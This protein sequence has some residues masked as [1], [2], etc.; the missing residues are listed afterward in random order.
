[1]H[2]RVLI[3]GTVPYNKQSSSRAFESYFHNWEKENLVQIY[4]NPREPVHGHCSSFYQITDKRMLMRHFNK[5]VKTGVIFY[6]CE[7][8]DEWKPLSEKQ[9]RSLTSKLYGLGSRK[10]PMNYLMRGWL[11]KQK[12]WCVPQLNKWLNEFQPE[13]VFLAFSDDYFIPQIAL[14]IAERFYI[15]IVS[16]IGDDYYFNDRK[17]FSPAYY[18]Y[19]KTYKQ[20]IN[21]VF[22]HGGSAAY[23]GDKIRDKY[24]QEFLLNGKTVYLTSEIERHEFRPINTE[25]PFISYCG[26]IRLGRNSSI[27][28]VADALAKINSTYRVHVY[29]NETEEMYYKQLKENQNVVFHGAVPYAEVM[30]IMNQSDV[31]LVVEGFEKK[32]VDIT[33]Y[34]LSTKVAD[35]LAVGGAVLALGS[36]ECGAIEYM[37]R[38]ACGPV[39][40]N[41]GDLDAAIRKLFSDVEYQKENYQKSMEVSKRNHTLASSNKIFESLVEESI[42]DYSKK[43]KN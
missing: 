36:I 8:Q 29:S 12:F 21:R 4:S 27:C 22:A 18:I 40:T 15:P 32:D 31:L 2:P 6:D 7:L 13:C 17:S 1:M 37:K 25:K 30:K 20:L 38:I 9:K 42:L 19:R 41:I 39:C 16:C 5:N 14:Y 10:A 24:N 33:R 3:V 35:S 11:W 23:I 28:A 43:L 26:N 34:S